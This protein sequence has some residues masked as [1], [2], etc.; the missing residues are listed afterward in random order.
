MKKYSIFVL[1]FVL[2]AAMLVGCGCTNRDMGQTSVPT[3]LPTNEE[4]HPTTRETTH[5]TTAPT[6][7]ATS[8]PTD[9]TETIDRGNGPLDNTTT[10]TT[11][12]TENGN[13]RSITGGNGSAGRSMSRG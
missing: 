4:V 3:V 9:A 6:T 10:G 8:L 7:N 13:A 12:A 1:V 11:G 2:T 5:A